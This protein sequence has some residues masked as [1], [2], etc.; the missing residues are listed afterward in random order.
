MEEVIRKKCRQ[1]R[2][3]LNLP[4][5]ID[6][7]WDGAVMDGCVVAVATGEHVLLLAFATC[8]GV[9]SSVKIK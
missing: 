5:N 9:T 8:R 4:S 3:S 6:L 2:Q 1:I 7:V